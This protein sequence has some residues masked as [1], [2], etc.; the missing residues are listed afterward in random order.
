[1][2]AWPPKGEFF[3]E[4]KLDSLQNDRI[5]RLTED[6]N[7]IE[8]ASSNYQKEKT[9]DNLEELINSS[10]RFI[11]YFAS[12]YGGGYSMDD[13]R[14]A[15][16][17]G[18]LKAI[19]NFDPKFGVK[20]STYAGHCIIGGIRHYVRKEMQYYRPGSIANLH[21][22][23]DHYLEDTFKETGDVPDPKEISGKFNV[24]EDS[25]REIM[26]AGLVS[27]DE[28]KINRISNRNNESFKLALEDRIILQQAVKRL[29][30]VQQNVIR[31]LFYHDMTQEA[32]SDKLGMN[33]RMVSRLK[34]KS[35][36]ELRKLLA[37]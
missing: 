14:Q 34:E 36:L 5:N 9:Q 8:I 15:G 22:K 10:K 1:M 13:L 11:N 35:I 27:L 16:M 7:T 23:I 25:V 30:T 21:S 20:F 33:Q 29:S 31:M 37:E 19:K 2:A 6:D 32:A 3:V 24:R 28:I 18:F 26:K 4:S 17:E 12:I